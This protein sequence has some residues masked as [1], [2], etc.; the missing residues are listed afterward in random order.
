VL[1]EPKL[2]AVQLPPLIASAFAR[3]RVFFYLKPAW[4]SAACAAFFGPRHQTRK[5]LMAKEAHTKA[6]EH[7]ETAAKSH[8]TAAEHHG[9]G[10]HT[11]GREESGKAQTHSKAAHEHSETAHGKSKAVK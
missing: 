8:R 1:V 9:K 11:K 6:A 4:N 7:H 10:D 3:G 2:V 5:K